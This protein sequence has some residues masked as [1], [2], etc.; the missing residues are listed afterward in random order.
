MCMSSVYNICG[1][2]FLIKCSYSETLIILKDFKVENSNSID[3]EIEIT[4]SDLEKQME[5]MGIF[6]PSFVENLVIL[7]KISNVLINECNAFIFHGSAIEYDNNAY[8]F[9]A[10]SGTGKSTHV[11][12][13]IKLL[14]DKIRYIN[15]DKPII[16]IENGVPFVYGSPWQGKHFL[17]NNIKAKLKG[18]ISLHR[19]EENK[20][21]KLSFMEFLPSLLEQAQKPNTLK[22][23][24]ILLNMIFSI[25]NSKVNF[26]SLYCNK[27]PSS[28]K[29]TYEYILKDN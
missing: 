3:Y 16:K 12:N 22:E 15:D 28:A 23:G 25:S 11:N 29:T 26:Y 9:S 18:V 4:K 8:I 21:N 5:F 7:N 24:Q 27:E 1:Y 2:Y 13:L 6:E 17:G 19:G 20:V 10:P 14:G